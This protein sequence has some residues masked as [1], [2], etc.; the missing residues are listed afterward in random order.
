M[1]V[2]VSSNKVDLAS[3]YSCGMPCATN[4]AES[5]EVQCFLT[6]AVGSTRTCRR[7]LQ[8]SNLQHFDFRAPMIVELARSRVHG[9]NVVHGAFHAT[10]RSGGDPDDDRASVAS[11]NCATVSESGSLARLATIAGAAPETGGDSAHLPD[12]D[13]LA[14]AGAGA[15]GG[16]TR[17]ANKAVTSYD[18]AL[19]RQLQVRT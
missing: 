9:R 16:A 11:T 14:S 2:G 1:K 8:H 19:L 12:A 7:N 6:V 10:F 17:R 15:G 5:Y 18:P 4:A 13:G 3:L